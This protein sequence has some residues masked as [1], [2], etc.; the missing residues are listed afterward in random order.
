MHV[1]TPHTLTNTSTLSGDISACAQQRTNICSCT[2]GP[3]AECRVTFTDTLKDRHKARSRL[4]EISLVHRSF[5][6]PPRWLCLED[7]Q[8]RRRL[9]ALWAPGAL[10]SLLISAF[11]SVSESELCGLSVVPNAGS[12]GQTVWR[13]SRGCSRPGVAKRHMLPYNQNLAL[14]G[15][16]R[17]GLTQSGRG[18]P[19]T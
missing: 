17:R 10:R 7:S 12:P 11:Y 14:L 2:D 13:G 3:I 16:G 1:H 6:S 5:T 4:R 9:W 18:G 19:G 15:V 8:L